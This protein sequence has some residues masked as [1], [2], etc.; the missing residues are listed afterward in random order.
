MTIFYRPTQNHLGTIYRRNQFY[1]FVGDE[2]IVTLLPFVERTGPEIDLGQRSV[3]LSLPELMTNECFPVD[4]D[5][6]VFYTVDPRT[7]LDQSFKIQAIRFSRHDWDGI[8]ATHARDIASNQVF[9]AF[10]RQRVFSSRARQQIQ[11]SLG[12]R[13]ADRVDRLGIQINPASGLSIQDLQPSERMRSAFDMD[14]RASLEARANAERMRAL[15][16]LFDER[17]MP[18]AGMARA[19]QEISTLQ[20]EGK[21]PV[22]Y[23]MLGTNGHCPNCGRERNGR[24]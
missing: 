16:R 8:I 10:N 2:H 21:L 3:G 20:Q 4:L 6:K 1:C 19:W 7:I 18:D 23:A 5:I 12:G 22:Q 24:G 15:A 9:P 13:L 17:Q 14:Q 11:E